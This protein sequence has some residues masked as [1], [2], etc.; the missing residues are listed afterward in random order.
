MSIGRPTKVISQ[1]IEVESPEKVNNSSI[2]VGGSDVDASPVSTSPGSN[3]DCAMPSPVLGG[4]EARWLEWAAA[5]PTGTVDGRT[6]E[7]FRRLQAVQNAGL[8]TGEVGLVSARVDSAFR[9]T[10]GKLV[11]SAMFGAEEIGVETAEIALFL[12]ET[13]YMK[14]FLNSIDVDDSSKV[15]YFSRL[16]EVLQSKVT[17]VRDDY[18]FATSESHPAIG[19]VSEVENPPLRFSDTKHLKLKELWHGATKTEFN[20][21]VD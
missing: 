14:D 6:S 18:F 10:Q 11:G 8:L 2:G 9:A 16:E 7:D 13:Q 20:G 21:L 3:A 12:S 15:T 19:H 17:C 5:G 4:R 1:P